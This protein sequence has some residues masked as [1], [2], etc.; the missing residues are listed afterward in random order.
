MLKQVST[1]WFWMSF[2][3]ISIRR[4]FALK[5]I[6]IYSIQNCL[7]HIMVSLWDI[8]INE[9]TKRRTEDSR[10][11]FITELLLRIRM[12]GKISRLELD[13]VEKFRTTPLKCHRCDAKPSNIRALKLH[14]RVHS[15]WRPRIAWFWFEIDKLLF[16]RL[17]NMSQVICIIHFSAVNLIKR[18]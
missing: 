12:H 8:F 4:R 17:I 18:Q 1:I 13:L 11:F 7:F 3:W 9:R 2:R 10:T 15:N 6:G 5:Y 14:L 16:F